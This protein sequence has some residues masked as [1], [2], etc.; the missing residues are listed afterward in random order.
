M[1][2]LLSTIKSDMEDLEV[3]YGKLDA[4]MCVLNPARSSSPNPK[5]AIAKQHMAAVT[6]MLLTMTDD[7]E[8]R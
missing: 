4:I 6:A 7:N 1:K 3:Q 2:S 5:F 8:V